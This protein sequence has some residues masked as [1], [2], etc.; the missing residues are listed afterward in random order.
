VPDHKENKLFKDSIDQTAV[1]RLGSAL[2]A[3]SP[4]FP[5]KDFQASGCD[6]LA[7]LELKDRVRHL[8]AVMTDY[9]P[10]DYPKALQVVTKAGKLWPTAAQG[11]PDDKLA[12]FA[13]WPLIDWVG[14]EGL[15]HPE[16]S[17]AAL[18][19]LTSLFSAEF[20]IRPFLTQHTELTLA[21]L[22]TWIDD[23]DHHVR[24]L[25]SEGTRPLL[26]WGMRLPLFRDDPAPVLELLEVLQDDE[27]E[28]VRRSVANNL[29]DIAKDHP[30][31]IAEVANSW[32]AGAS[33]ERQRLVK[34]GLRTL[35][36]QGHPGALQALGFTVNP[37]VEASLTVADAELQEGQSLQLEAVI[38]S[39]SRSAQKLVVDYAVHYR[40]A[41]GRL[42]A[43]I[44]KWKTVDLA[45]GQTVTLNKKQKMVSRSVRKLYGGRHEVHLLVAGLTADQGSFSLT[46]AGDGQESG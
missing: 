41:N 25:I 18:R 4:D 36:K 16:I 3:A 38:T 14:V 19:Q 37:K 22:N 45:P 7:P 39:R 10:D 44:F 23:G 46:M 30:D 43:K 29:N 35:I 8:M 42:S 31:L 15:D 2:K 20:A 32:L 1:A 13:A 33:L 26:P 27:S 11:D 9:L 6:G 34:H 28:Y 12:G 17:L 5:R 24:R 40:K 21:T